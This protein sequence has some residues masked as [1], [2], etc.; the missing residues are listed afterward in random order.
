MKKIRARKNMINGPIIQLSNRE[1]DRILMFFKNF[2][3]LFVFDFANG[4]Y[5]IKTRQVVY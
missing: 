5:I 2:T 3:H 4:G 1:V